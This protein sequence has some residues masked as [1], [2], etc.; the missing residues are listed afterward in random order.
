MIGSFPLFRSSTARQTGRKPFPRSRSL[1][2][3]VDN[4]IICF[5]SWCQPEVRQELGSFRSV[6]RIA[7]CPIVSS[8]LCSIPFAPS[9]QTSYRLPFAIDILQCHDSSQ[10]I[11][12]DS[13]R[14]CLCTWFKFL[15]YHEKFINEYELVLKA[16]KVSVTFQSAPDND[17]PMRMP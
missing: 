15:E 11:P 13:W 17:P 14:G 5:M 10:A 2:S 3:I 7:A 6:Q 1:D 4:S 9:R 16:E 8:H 12:L